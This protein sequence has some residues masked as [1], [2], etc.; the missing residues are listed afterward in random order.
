MPEPHAPAGVGRFPA[1]PLAGEVDV[2]H[3][4]GAETPFPHQI[5]VQIQTPFLTEGVLASTLAELPLQASK[6]LVALS[7]LSPHLAQHLMV[8]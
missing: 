5:P 4:W 6:A 2:M 1:G 3:H 7:T 8:V